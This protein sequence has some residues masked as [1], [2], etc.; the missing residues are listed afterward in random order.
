MNINKL[1]KKALILGASK[2]GLSDRINKRFYVIYH[3][4]Y[5]HFGSKMVIHILI[6][7]MTKLKKIGLRDIQRL[8]IRKVNML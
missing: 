3:N 6:T 1:E 4:K 8:Q 5:I 7:T 2:F